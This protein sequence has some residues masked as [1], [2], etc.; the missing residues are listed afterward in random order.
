MKLKTSLE[1]IETTSKQMQYFM[2]N[3][4]KWFGNLTLEDDGE[5]PK[6]T[7]LNP[8]AFMIFT[9]GIFRTQ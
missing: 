9:K 4:E 7:E 1:T 6:Y 8:F 3:S 5:I 2:K